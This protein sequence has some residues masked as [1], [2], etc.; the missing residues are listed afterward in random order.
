MAGTSAVDV[1]FTE[2]PDWLSNAYLLVNRN[3]GCGVLIDGNGVADAL[4]ERINRDRIRIE[5]ILL[6]HHHVDHVLFD[7]YRQFSAPVF[8]HPQTSELAVLNV[9][10]PLA[11]SEVF[12]AAGLRIEA[13]HT[14]GHAIDH[15]AF[16]V[17]GVGCFTGDILFRGTVGGTRGPSGT[18]LADL[19]SSIETV[20]SL[21]EPTRLFPGHRQSTTVA[22]ELASN[23]FVMAWRAGIAPLDEECTVRG[24]PATLL[25]WGPDYDGTNKAWVRLASGEDHVVGGSLVER[26]GSPAT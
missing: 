19:R 25:L 10:H 2:S 4:L 24:E 16:L 11:N 9:D 6:T 20:L 15:V 7:D 1:E 5:A 26:R 3:S 14:P 13:L 21:P 22:D 18:D 12:E 8:A 23:P 17:D